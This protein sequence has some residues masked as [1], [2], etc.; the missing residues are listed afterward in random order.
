MVF[1]LLENLLSIEFKICY[2][3]TDRRLP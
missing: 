2:C 3:H 1:N